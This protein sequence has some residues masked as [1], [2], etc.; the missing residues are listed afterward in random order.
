[1]SWRKTCWL[2]TDL[3][4]AQVSTRY[5]INPT[6]NAGMPMDKAVQ[7]GLVEPE[8]HEKLL[9]AEEAVTGYKVPYSGQSILPFLDLEKVLISRNQCLYLLNTQLCTGSIMGPS[10]PWK[11]QVSGATWRRSQ[12][13]LFW[14][15]GTMTRWHKSR[16]GTAYSSSD[17][18]LISWQLTG[19]SLLPLWESY[20]GPKEDFLTDIQAS[21][22]FKKAA[23]EILV[24]SFTHT[25]LFTQ[26]YVSLDK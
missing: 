1:M 6:M 17:T 24:G 7:D 4:E 23:A 12:T 21:E 11:S 26:T 10:C 2:I 9:S 13:T 8:L 14:C 15:P 25:G 20:L 19:L 22:S 16:S 18:G 3:L 5:I